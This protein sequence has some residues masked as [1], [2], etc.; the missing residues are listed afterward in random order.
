MTLS[1]EFIEE[2]KQRLLEDKTKFQKELGL[3]EAEHPNEASDLTVEFPNFTDEMGDE[4]GSAAEVAEYEV[5]LNVEQDLKRALRDTVR[6]L[7]RIKDGTYGICKYCG[8][9][10]PEERM[11]ARPTSGSCIECKKT[12][13]QEA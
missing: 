12:I 5:N 7:K 8:K 6:A 9:Q 11:R 4:E 3:V 13:A 1:K 10:I 2:M